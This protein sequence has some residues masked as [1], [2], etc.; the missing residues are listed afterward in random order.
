MATKSLS[1]RA[2]KERID[3]HEQ[4]IREALRKQSTF[5]KYDALAVERLLQIVRK[6]QVA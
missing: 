4:K 1:K 3:A 6:S 2:V 5:G